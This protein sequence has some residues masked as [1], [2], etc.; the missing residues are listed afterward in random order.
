M[1]KLGLRCFSE[2]KTPLKASIFYFQQRFYF[3][4]KNKD[5]LAIP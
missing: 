3:S 1:R 4:G 2:R 5:F